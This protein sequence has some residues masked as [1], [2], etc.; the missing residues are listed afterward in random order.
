MDGAE[1]R[2]LNSLQVRLSVAASVVVVLFA[3]LAGAW[4]FAAAFNDAKEIQDAELE[5]ISRLFGIHGLSLPDQPRPA[6]RTD[7]VSRIAIE[8]VGVAGQWPFGL[9]ADVP[10]GYLTILVAGESWR[11]FVRTTTRSHLRLAVGQR[12][13]ARDHIAWD[14]GLWTA[15]PLL[16]LVP[17]L[18]S[19]VFLLVRRMLKPIAVLA[20][21]LDR[22][23]DSDLSSAHVPGLPSEMRPIMAAIN[24]LLSR[25]ARSMKAQRR[26]IADAAHE[27]RSPLAALS[28]QAENVRRST[29]SEETERRLV[30]LRQ[31]IARVRSLLEQ[32]LSLARAHALSDTANPSCAAETVL[33]T[34]LE[35]L[36]PQAEAKKIDLD[37]VHLA[38]SS[39]AASELDLTVVLRNLLDNAIRYSSSGC[40]VEIDV[41]ASSQAAHI[42]VSDHGPGVPETERERIFDPFYRILGGDEVGTGLGLSIVKTIVQRLGGA[43]VL[44]WTV[45]RPPTGLR[46]RV[47]LPL[48]RQDGPAAS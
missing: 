16:L 35:E 24:S 31:G 33:R 20:G 9:P 6:P 19:L 37:I 40:R 48:A 46:V 17:V 42:E 3:L 22:R 30:T 12:T 4:S 1:S 7:R 29:S 8:P 36:L 21:N 39:V 41:S 28:V 27:L 18:C 14:A 45:E 26:F 38:P 34:V 5:A 25:L 13:A 43:I 32:L 44:G 11:I 2:L 15:V 23:T 47:T 10:D